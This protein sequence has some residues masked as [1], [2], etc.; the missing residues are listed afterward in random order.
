MANTPK[1]TFKYMIRFAEL[2]GILSELAGG[3]S[4]RFLGKLI[5]NHFS[6]KIPT[7]NKAVQSALLTFYCYSFNSSQFLVLRNI[8]DM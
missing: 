4:K 3:S 2:H 1:E 7:W 5:K 6:N 8:I